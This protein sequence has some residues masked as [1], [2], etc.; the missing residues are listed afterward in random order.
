[1]NIRA[2]DSTW[3]LRDVILIRE[4][5]LIPIERDRLLLRDVERLRL[6]CPGTKPADR[7]GFDAYV[8]PFLK[9]LARRDRRMRQGPPQAVLPR[10]CP[11]AEHCAQK[12][13]GTPSV[14]AQ[15]PST[16]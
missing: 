15:P 12:P 11:H 16:R 2:P 4:R 5:L 13:S 3:L 10:A 9:E 14:R 6:R 7:R 8:A 1:M